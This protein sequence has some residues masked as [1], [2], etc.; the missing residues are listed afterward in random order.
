[1]DM[2]SILSFKNLSIGY[3]HD[4]I[5]QGLNMELYQGE[6]LQ[7]IGANGSG[8]TTLIKTLL[9]EIPAIDGEIHRGY[10]TS[11]YLKQNYQEEIHLPITVN[12]ILDREAQ[13]IDF[14]TDLKWN[15]LSGGQKQQVLILKAFSQQADLIVLDEPLNHLD[16]Q[17]IERVSGLIKQK[18]NENKLLTVIIISHIPIKFGET[19]RLEL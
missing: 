14:S 1:M 15:D 13:N 5:V 3:S 8:K 6:T 19:K 12:E 4:K 18:L 10:K 16:I 7:I 11:Y 9:G 17:S 2:N